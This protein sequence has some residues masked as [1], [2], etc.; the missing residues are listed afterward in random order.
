MLYRKYN[1]HTKINYINKLT[2]LLQ[3]KNSQQK[4]LVNF[5]NKILDYKPL[6]P[7]CTTPAIY[8]EVGIFF[9]Y[10]L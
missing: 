8:L 7:S 5:L 1:N 6:L 10:Y 2:K 9:Y 3:R 4:D